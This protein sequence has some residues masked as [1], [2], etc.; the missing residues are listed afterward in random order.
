MSTL[1]A[2]VPRVFAGLSV[3]CERSPGDRA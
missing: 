1:P 3:I 2:V